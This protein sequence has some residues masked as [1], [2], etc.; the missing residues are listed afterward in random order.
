M[1][2]ICAFTKN[3]KA[4]VKALGKTPNLLTLLVVISKCLA[5]R[6]SQEKGVNLI[7]AENIVVDFICLL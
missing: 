4:R 3:K 7:E 2:I 6:I 5:E 1:E